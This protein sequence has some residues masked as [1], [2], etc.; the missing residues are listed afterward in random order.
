MV[1]TVALGKIDGDA[2]AVELR[3][4]PAPTGAGFP[5]LVA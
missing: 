3:A 2:L 1:V 4:L 5:G